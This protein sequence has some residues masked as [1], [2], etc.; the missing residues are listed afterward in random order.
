M[1]KSGVLFS[2]SL[3]GL[4]CILIMSCGSSKSYKA[5]YEAAWNEIV[6]S[7]EWKEALSAENDQEIVL[8]DNAEIDQWL[9]GPKFTST[10]E[11]HFIKKYNYWVSRAYYK[12]IADAEIADAKI[13][14]EY[15]RFLAENP[16]A[17]LSSDENIVRIRGLYEKKYQSHQSML[18]GLKSWH[19]FEDYGS[20]DLKFFKAENHDV[21]RSM[22]RNGYKDDQIVNFLVYK[23]ADLYHLDRE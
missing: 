15:E 5:K 20:D 17:K 19:A 10:E 13:K 9:S 11:T 4:F 14:A 23:L 3:A 22:Y 21:V 2:I 1:K 6:Q 12:L 16:D 7:G 18:E 8:D